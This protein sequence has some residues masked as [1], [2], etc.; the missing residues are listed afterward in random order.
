MAKRMPLY[1]VWNPPTSSCSA[2]TR[3]NGG[4]FVSA[5]AA[6]RKTTKGTMAAVRIP[7]LRKESTPSHACFTTNE[8]IDRL[9]VWMTAA[10]TASDIAAS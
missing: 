3:S 6:R 8:C 9:P 4:W 7:Q 10:S 2:S 1:S 5:A